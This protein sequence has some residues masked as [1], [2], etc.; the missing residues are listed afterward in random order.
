MIRFQWSI[1][2]SDGDR[3]YKKYTELLDTV[4]IVY[5]YIYINIVIEQECTA[6][7]TTYHE[8]GLKD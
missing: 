2:D 3:I 6:E 4:Y 5:V 7:S 1:K 8:W